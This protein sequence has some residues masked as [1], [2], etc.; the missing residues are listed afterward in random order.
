MDALCGR[1]GTCMRMKA[2]P[3]A[4]DLSNGT[5]W[6]RLCD[7]SNGSWPHVPAA[8]STTLRFYVQAKHTA[9]VHVHHTSVGNMPVSHTLLDFANPFPLDLTQHFHYNCDIRSPAQEDRSKGQYDMF[10]IDV[11]SSRAV[12]TAS[13]A[14]HIHHCCPHASLLPKPS[15]ACPLHTITWDH[16]PLFF[17][18][19]ACA[20]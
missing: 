6:L 13:G 5:H 1:V 11:P 3:H 15:R 10:S 9:H 2:P 8:C 7:S 18:H 12:R 20:E 19:Q 14:A 17:I 4:V 16:G